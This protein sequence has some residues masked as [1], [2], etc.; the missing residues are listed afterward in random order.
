[1]FTSNLLPNTGNFQQQL[2][3]NLPF[4]DVSSI[5]GQWKTC[6]QRTN[7]MSM[8][9]GT[10]SRIQPCKLWWVNCKQIKL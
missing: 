3:M 8:V 9:S 7:L 6:W 1:M 5:W 4:N 2:S 10:Y